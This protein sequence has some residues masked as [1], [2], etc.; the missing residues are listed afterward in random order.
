MTVYIQPEIITETGEIVETGGAWDR[1][2]RIVGYRNLAE[3]TFLALGEELYHFEDEKQ[4]L[5]LD[6]PTFESYLARTDVNIGRTMAFRLKA[7]YITL[8]I[9]LKV[10]STELLEAGNEKVSMLLPY[11]N[12]GDIDKST[13][14]SKAW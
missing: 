6:E 2:K 7:I 12:K 3:K 11:I 4:Y 5:A 9:G 8:T 1:H 10:Q 14:L 13:T